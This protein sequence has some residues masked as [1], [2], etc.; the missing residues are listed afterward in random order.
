MSPSFAGT[1]AAQRG[2]LIKDSD[3]TMTTMAPPLILIGIMQPD[4][5]TL[6][7]T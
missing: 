4:R 5:L 3:S 7:F 2:E 6:V 1:A